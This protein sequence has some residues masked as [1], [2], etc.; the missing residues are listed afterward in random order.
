MFKSGTSN[1]VADALSRTTSCSSDEFLLLLVPNFDFMDDLRR[2]L[3]SSTEF[4]TQLSKVCT[5]PD[6]HPDYHV[7]NELLLFWN[8]I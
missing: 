5:N 2:T 8:R 7:H 4:Q 6:N 3:H 1:A